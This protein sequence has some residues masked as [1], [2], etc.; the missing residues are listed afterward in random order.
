MRLAQEIAATDSLRTDGSCSWFEQD[1]RLVGSHS[2]PVRVRSFSVPRRDREDGRIVLV[3]SC[4]H[5]ETASYPHKPSTSIPDVRD[6][7][8]SPS[9]AMIGDRFTV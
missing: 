8:L 9:D 5:Q 4:R 1:S 2:Y 7:G 3:L 6:T